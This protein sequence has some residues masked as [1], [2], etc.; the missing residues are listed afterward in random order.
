MKTEFQNLKTRKVTKILGACFLLAGCLSAMSTEAQSMDAQTSAEIAIPTQ[1]R[2]LLTAEGLQTLLG[3]KSRDPSSRGAE[4]SQEVTAPAASFK[5]A[6]SNAEIKQIATTLNEIR[7]DRAILED[8]LRK[9]AEEKTEALRKKRKQ[10]QLSRVKSGEKGH[11]QLGRQLFASLLAEANHEAS[12]EA[13]LKNFDNTHRVEIQ[14][15]QSTEGEKEI[16][17]IR[18]GRD[19]VWSDE[20]LTA[21]M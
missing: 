12:V 4:S 13:A 20:Y 15:V 1:G 16:L 17:A 8:K 14:Y 9:E 21:G 10:I 18:V 2:A 7:M 3:I 19:T 11:Q 5:Y 6:L